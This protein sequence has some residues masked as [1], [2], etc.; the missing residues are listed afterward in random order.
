VNFDEGIAAALSGVAG[1]DAVLAG[2]QSCFM[3]EYCHHTP[4]EDHWFELRVTPN[5]TQLFTFGAITWNR[6]VIHFDRTQAQAEG[7][8]D[9]IATALVRAPWIR[10]M[11]RQGAVNYSGK[12]EIDPRATGNALGARYIVTGSFQTQTDGLQTLTAQLV[13]SEDGSL[14]W[15][16]KFDR[17]PELSV[18]RDRINGT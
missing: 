7:F 2:S 3:A 8:S 14:L 4:T 18:L 16:D 1:I 15:A 5:R 12:R 17:P 6:H 9:D 10:V 11:S 13:S